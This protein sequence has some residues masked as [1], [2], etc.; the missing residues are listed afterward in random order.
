M[1]LLQV[2]I[3]TGKRETV[4]RV[5]EDYEIDY[6]VTEETSHRGYTA[7][8]YF[9]LPSAAVQDVLDDLQ[10]AGLSDE[11]Y[12][13]VMAA[14][15]VVSRKFDKLQKRYEEDEDNGEQVAREELRATAEDLVRSVPTYVILTV[16]SAVIATVGLLLDSPA[17]VVGSMVIAPLIGPAMSASVGTVVDDADLV[18]RGIKL[19]VLGL[20]LAVVAAALFALFIRVTS[21]VPPGLDPTTI[22]Q[23]E[24]RLA[25]DFLSLVVALGAGVAG[26]MSLTAGVSSALVGVMIAVALIPPAATMG[27]GI[28]YGLPVVALSS[29]VLTLVNVLSINLAALIVFW[30]AGYRPHN[31]LRREEAYSKTVKRVGVLV[32]AIAI[33]SLFL[34]AV[35]YDSVS[36]AEIE[37]QIHAD[38]D[39]V[40]DEPAFEEVV[41]LDVSVRQTERVI[42][43]EPER[44]TVTVGVPPGM[45]PPDLADRLDDR[46]DRSLEHDVTVEVRIVRTVV[47][48]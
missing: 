20:V 11:A 21:L 16:V 47:S 7:I 13:V 19:Q 48:Q 14:E 46:I 41:L 35:T 37:R 3:P 44:V 30:Y 17:V 36:S 1:R 23:V 5:L 4:L 39:A 27:I 12:T 29:G 42:F 24:A 22:G 26:A 10:D 18:D 38:I 33:L 2:T 28:A 32:A 45:D 34:G 15:T 31:F 9:P 8:V 43:S 25:P 6:V 40:L